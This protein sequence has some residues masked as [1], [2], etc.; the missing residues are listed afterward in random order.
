MKLLYTILGLAILLIMSCNKDIIQE[1]PCENYV[2]PT[3]KI[4]FDPYLN[5][6]PDNNN[7]TVQRYLQF[8]S[9]FMDTSIYHHSWYLGT[10][11]LSTAKF[12][13]DFS[14]ETVPKTYTI[15]HTMRWQPNNLCDPLDKGYD[16]TSFNF[17]ITNKYNDLNILGKYRV[18]FDSVP[19]DSIDIELF[20]AQFNF[21]DSIVKN[22][23]QSSQNLPYDGDKGVGSAI[24]LRLKGL[25]LYYHDGIKRIIN[26][27][28]SFAI[29]NANYI[30]F[31]DLTGQSSIEGPG[32]FYINPLTQKLEL[33]FS[34]FNYHYLLHGRKL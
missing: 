17:T 16:S 2:R 19:Y 14:S 9:N 10:E 32:Q 31:V 23:M 28:I 29:I 8:R 30:S 4:Y 11:T 33:T 7:L 26:E 20:F 13:R 15:F 3:A 18:S 27:E 22:P 25:N 6:T 1:P 34:F 5:S 24:K 21:R 12:W